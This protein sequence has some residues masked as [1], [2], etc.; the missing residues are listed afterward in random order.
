MNVTSRRL[1]VRCVLAAGTVIAITIAWVETKLLAQE[2]QA[3]SSPRHCVSR[4]TGR[5]RDIDFIANTKWVQVIL[6]RDAS[7]DLIAETSNFQI[8][9]IVETAFSLRSAVSVDYPVGPS[10]TGPKHL[11][12][13]RLE[14]KRP[15]NPGEVTSVAYEESEATCFAVIWDKGKNIEVKTQDQRVQS[16]IETAIRLKL[17][18]QELTYDATTKV[19]TRV[20]VNSP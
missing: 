8:V 9:S 13:V 15:M 11:T 12:C 10:S 19:I 20:K 2:D 3:L 14:L 6:N 5:P 7:T 4:F 17:P 16:I 18:V 1:I